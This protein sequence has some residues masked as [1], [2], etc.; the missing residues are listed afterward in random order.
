MCYKRLVLKN[1]FS[2]VLKHDRGS[3]IVHCDVEDGESVVS[4]IWCTSIDASII[5]AATLETIRLVLKR[6]EAKIQ[7]HFFTKFFID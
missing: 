2:L 4:V 6:V 7:Q 5:L 3:F 1:F